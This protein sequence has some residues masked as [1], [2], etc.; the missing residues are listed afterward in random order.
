MTAQA[1]PTADAFA[2]ARRLVRAQAR[3][4]DARV[5]AWFERPDD[6]KALHG[7]RTSM[8]RLRVL[9]LSFRTELGPLSKKKVRRRLREAFRASSA[10]RDLD[11]FVD[12]LRTLPPSGAIGHLVAAA[13]AESRELTPTVRDVMRTS[14]RDV[15]RRLR[16][17]LKAGRTT[18]RSTTRSFGAAAARAA[19]AEVRAIEKGL[20]HMDPVSARDDV[21]ETRIVAKRLRYLVEALAG[22]SPESHRVVKWCRTFQDVVGEW[23]DATLAS[24]RVRACPPIAGRPMVMRRLADR[25]RRALSNLRCFVADKV[26]WRVARREALALAQQ[27]ASRSRDVTREATDRVRSA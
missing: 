7:A 13:E 17:P 18:Q 1:R 21:H 24:G 25:R 19:R 5:E 3:V 15:R 11:V 6:R 8:R 14:W 2:E 4:V 16:S 27:F 9:M 12:W 10:L 23:R 26:A 22:K 20:A